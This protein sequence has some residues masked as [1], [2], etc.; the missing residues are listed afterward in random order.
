MLNKIGTRTSLIYSAI[1]K[2]GYDSFTL[3][4][5]EYCQMDILIKREQHYLNIL[6]PKY[7]ILKAAN[8]RLGS[9]HSLETKTLMSIK[10]KGKNHPFFGKTLSEE[11]RINI[12]ESLKS[13][14]I[15]KKSVKSRSKIKTKE[16]KLKMSLRTKGV[17]VKVF[18]LENNLI[19]EF[20]TMI[21][22]ALYLG[23]S[24]R[25]VGRYLDNDIPYKNYIFKS[26]L[27]SK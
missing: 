5:L 21:S 11:T 14:L 4:I 16:T 6:K 20:P 25:T 7:N 12:S 8:S 26:N 2:Y 3:D 27:I 24:T 23:I 13:S 1:L 10:L 15:F 22:L 18:D 19:K 17:R 9:K